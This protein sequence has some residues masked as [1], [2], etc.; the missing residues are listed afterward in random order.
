MLSCLFLPLICLIDCLRDSRKNM[1]EQSLTS[2]N[3]EN[4][5]HKTGRIN[6]N[7]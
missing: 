6:I 4:K 7:N 2:D 3:E 5:V 1:S